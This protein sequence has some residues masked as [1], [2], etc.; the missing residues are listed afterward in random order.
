MAGATKV[1]GSGHEV[2]SRRNLWSP[3]S[4]GMGVREIS[5]CRYHRNLC[6]DSVQ[7]EVLYRRRNR[8]LNIG[9]GLISDR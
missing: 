1:G 4:R 7:L 2:S 3:L 6:R 9:A 8:L 5:G